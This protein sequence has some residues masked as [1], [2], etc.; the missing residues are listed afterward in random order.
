MLARLPETPLAALLSVGALSARLDRIIRGTELGEMGLRSYVTNRRDVDVWLLRTRNCGTRSVRE[1]KALVLGHVQNIL[2]TVDPVDREPRDIKDALATL[3]VPELTDGPVV[4]ASPWPRSSAIALLPDTPLGQ[5]LRPDGLS[6]RLERMLRETE[7]GQVGLTS[8]VSDRDRIESWMLRTPNCGRRSVGELRAS[9]CAHV[10][11]ILSAAGLGPEEA[12]ASAEDLLAAQVQREPRVEGPPDGLDLK[13]L[14]DWH[15][16]R[17]KPRSA[18]ILSRRFGLKGTPRQTLEEIGRDLKVTRERIRQV[19]AKE[20]KR[21]RE[22]CARFPLTLQLEDERSKV[23]EGLFEDRIHVKRSEVEALCRKLDGHL[24]LA[25][26]IAGMRPTDWLMC[27]A[28]EVKYG[29]LHRDANRELFRRC[30]DELLRRSAEAPMPRSVQAL[31]DGLDAR[32][33]AAALN[34]ELG[35]HVAH[36]YV[37]QRRPGTR[38]LRTAMLHSLLSTAGRPQG[39]ADLLIRYHE[40]VP[41]DLCSDR[42]LIIVM[43]EAPHLFLEIEE[44]SWA[45]LG[46]CGEP[47]ARSLRSSDLAAVLDEDA[48]DDGTVASALERA[49]R[50]RGPTRVGTLIDDALDI[51]PSGRSPRSVGPTLLMNPS[52]FVRA[53]PGVWALCEQIPNERETA[54]ADNL[55]YLLNPSQ[56]KTYALARHAGEPWGCYPLWTPT[57]EMRLCRWARRHGE[58]ELLSSLLAI[59]TID[60]WPTAAEDKAMWSDAKERGARFELCFQPRQTYFALTPDRVLALALAL[61]DHGTIGW[62]TVNRI[63]RY[64]ACAHIAAPVLHSLSDMGIVVAAAGSTSWQLP[65][66]RGPRLAEWIGRLSGLIH[67]EGEVEWWHEE[68][69]KAGTQFMAEAADSSFEPAVEEMDELESLMADHRRALQMRRLQEQFEEAEA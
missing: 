36:G 57:A 55:H 37:F 48:I 67:R 51:L 15:L 52:R 39:V 54:V 43:E 9:A 25:V 66:Q 13:S 21:T 59:A 17:M 61:D 35:W 49:L 42:D 1:L 64:Q 45:A 10:Y 3:H 38:A 65:H 5:L 47:P 16:F 11:H 8:Y 27:D 69:Q 14:I 44:A 4:P 28:H 20:L 41:T 23:T 19:E 60:A 18:E 12:R 40:G 32:H 53:L 2:S 46:P 58:P 29:F 31:T 30:A 22:L 6:A 34:V 62:I 33:A 63:L 24:D 56:A 26:E 68:L 50:D 7:L